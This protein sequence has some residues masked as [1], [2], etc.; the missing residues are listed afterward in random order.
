MAFTSKNYTLH[1]KIF[2]VLHNS[3]TQD[4]WL[5]NLPSYTTLGTLS[6]AGLYLNPLEAG[7]ESM[8]EF[9]V[10]L[11]AWLNELIAKFFETAV[12][13]PVVVPTEPD[14]PPAMDAL[15]NDLI[16]N[17]SVTNNKFV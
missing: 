15:I 13:D 6:T 3:D 11:K 4:I 17:L 14:A 1:G 10:K 12:E 9:I 2:R 5:Q 16:T 8:D 7:Y